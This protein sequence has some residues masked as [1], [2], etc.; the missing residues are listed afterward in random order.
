[1]HHFFVQ[2]STTEISALWA[3]EKQDLKQSEIQFVTLR[4]YQ[5]FSK[6][7]AIEVEK[8]WHKRRYW[9]KLPRRQRLKHIMQT[10]GLN[11]GD[12]VYTPQCR[13]PFITII[14]FSK[15]TV[16]INLIE[17]GTSNYIY[18]IDQPPYKNS[19]RMKKNEIIITLLK[20]LFGQKNIYRFGGK[21]F[22]T[23]YVHNAFLL[24]EG[25]NTDFPKEKRIVGDFKNLCSRIE[26]NREN[27]REATSILVLDPLPS[28]LEEKI[29][30]VEKLISF[31]ENKKSL[32]SKV[33]IQPHSKDDITT[34][35]DTIKSR[36]LQI[37]I[38]SAPIEILN[39][40][41]EIT[42]IF[43]GIS[44][45]ALYAVLLD[46]P[47]TVIDF[48][49]DKK[50]LFEQKISQVIDEASNTQHIPS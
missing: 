8:N 47:I 33:I 20:L 46:I 41:H 10:I 14:H 31:V 9:K 23:S 16:R 15:L 12:Q 30:T 42:E 22:F 40:S 19:F 13:L 3:I 27:V 24:S 44:S 5:P 4:G 45:T 17:E 25:A 49:T 18:K 43:V 37:K 28:K 48:P 1:M 34:I 11:S 50:N 2:S 32:N 29:T 39:L 6:Y 36:S 38:S 26:P 35:S 21:V 7:A